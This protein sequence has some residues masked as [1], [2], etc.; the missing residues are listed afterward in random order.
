MLYIPSDAPSE[1]F[2]PRVFS[3]I[4]G[5]VEVKYILEAHVRSKAS[6]AFLLTGSYGLGK[7]SLAKIVAKGLICRDNTG[8]A[9]PCNKCE[10][11]RSM[12]RAVA[13][14]ARS[15]DIGA[16]G[17]IEEIREFST[18]I[19]NSP[20]GVS[21]KTC[22]VGILDEI[23][24]ASSKSFDMLLGILEPLPKYATILLLT[25]DPNR[26]P[27]TVRSRCRQLELQVVNPADC[28]TWARSFCQQR[29]WHA[30]DDVLRLIVRQANGH[31]RN[32]V[33]SLAQFGSNGNFS[34]ENVQS[35]IAREPKGHLFD[36]VHAAINNEPYAKQRRILEDWT[37]AFASKIDA[38]Q[39]LILTLLEEYEQFRDLRSFRPFLDPQSSSFLESFERIAFNQRL[40]LDTFLKELVLFWTVRQGQ[41]RQSLLNQKALA[42]RDLLHRASETV[43]ATPERVRSVTIKRELIAKE[44]STRGDGTGPYLD[45]HALQ[46]IWDVS[47]FMTQ[48]HGV[49]FNTRITFQHRADSKNGES[50]TAIM[51]RLTKQLAAALKRWDPQGGRLFYWVMLHENLS[52]AGAI[53]QLIAHIPEALHESTRFWLLGPFKR[54]ISG[55]SAQSRALRLRFCSSHSRS[56]RLRFHNFSLMTLSRSADPLLLVRTE[57]GQRRLLSELL[58]VRPCLQQSS[59]HRSSFVS[60]RVGISRSLGPQVREGV[61]KSAWPALKPFRDGAWRYLRSG[62]EDVEFRDREHWKRSSYTHSID[63]HGKSQ[64]EKNPDSRLPGGK[65][66][67]LLWFS[68]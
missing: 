9:D 62:W 47:S 42:F 12:D 67:Q 66:S 8:K 61:D 63:K 15:L 36:Y 57:H 59:S 19:K 27:P 2:R 58:G 18:F 1:Q 48:V 45:R 60:I 3:D 14:E 32:L 23:H 28:L 10:S 53:S 44:L 41:P 55:S 22:K 25:T 50:P 31:V 33:N 56:R 6:G 52:D 7:T 46:S 17:N 26:V 20:I 51:S 13:Y 24:S 68:Q 37:V 34:L 54:Q 39:D 65:R 29:N 30:S 5:Q 38:I 21:G 16:S 4:L 64:I 43:V 49:R 40:P 11:C 35:H